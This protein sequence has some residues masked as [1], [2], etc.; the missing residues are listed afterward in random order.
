MKLEYLNYYLRVIF[1]LNVLLLIGIGPLTYFY[2]EIY[3]DTEKFNQF[4]AISG[5]FWLAILFL[6]IYGVYDSKY[7][8]PL[9]FL[10]L[11][12]KSLFVIYFARNYETHTKKG[13][14]YVV[15]FYCF[16]SWI[17]LISGYII[18]KAYVKYN[19]KP[20]IDCS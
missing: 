12:Y 5:S 7:M 15:I 20:K 4:A 6:S 16:I 9:V 13:I 8:E 10:Q 2:P 11:I 17:V 18:L 14:P 3:S 1:I 19:S